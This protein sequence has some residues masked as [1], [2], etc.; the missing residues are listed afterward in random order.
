[1]LSA[2][3]DSVLRPNSSR[4]LTT[5]SLLAPMSTRI[6]SLSIR[7][8]VPSTTSPC[9]KLLISPSVSARSSSIVVGSGPVGFG[10]AGAGAAGDRGFGD[11]AGASAAGSSAAGGT[12]PPPRQRPRPSPG[13]SSAATWA[14]A[15]PRRS[16]R[17]RRL[18]GRL[19]DH[20]C[21]GR[22][23]RPGPRRGLVGDGLGSLGRG[24]R[25]VRRSLGVGGGR[26]GRGLGVVA[27]SSATAV[28]AALGSDAVA[29][30]VASAGVIDPPC[31][32]S[33]KW[34]VSCR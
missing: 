18:V 27:G 4:L 29:S 8:T 21:S 1:M 23:R 33:V 16:R 15:A 24:K 32:S 3:W 11:G 13:A 30:A 31:C 9:L 14:S 34:F 7:T 6:S 28:V 19:S 22:P 10:R 17:P 25:G 20:R 26:R 2:G 12:S 5:P